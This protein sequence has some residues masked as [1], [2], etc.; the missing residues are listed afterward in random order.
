MDAGSGGSIE[1]SL[2]KI[3]AD[4]QNKQEYSAWS[5]TICDCPWI[6]DRTKAIVK[7]DNSKSQRIVEWSDSLRKECTLRG[8]IW[9][10]FVNLRYYYGKQR[11]LSRH[12]IK[13]ILDI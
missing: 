4:A 10:E 6:S 1:I 8:R 5:K 11:N 13:R 12:D 9:A 7:K 2:K 3:Q